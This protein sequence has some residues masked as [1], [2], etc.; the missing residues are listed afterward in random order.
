MERAPVERGRVYF[1]L[2][3]LHAV[4]TERLRYAPLGWSKAFE[5]NEADLRCGLETVD[6]WID[7]LAAGRSN[8]PPEKIPWI[9]LR[10]LLSRT[11]YGGRID[12]PY[13]QRLL[14]SFI[15][16][17]FVPRSFEEGFELSLATHLP[18]PEGR[19]RS[20]FLQWLNRSLPDNESPAW[21]G[22]SDNAERLLM[23]VKGITLIR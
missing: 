2:A 11:V 3:W 17:L 16:H 8:I 1:L 13:D 21:L 22:L 20:D 18:A 15:D 5:F 4:V 7:T 19:S 12:N 6:H 10:T 9:A 23:S 14:E